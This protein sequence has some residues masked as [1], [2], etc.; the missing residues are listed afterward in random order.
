M[1]CPSPPTPR[2]VVRSTFKG[3]LKRK[4]LN[5]L[6]GSK[7][8]DVLF[9][10]GQLKKTGLFAGA[11]LGSHDPGPTS[12]G[13]SALGS[14]P[15][16]APSPHGLLPVSLLSWTLMALLVRAIPTLGLL[17]GCTSGTRP[18]TVDGHRDPPVTLPKGW[19][20][21]PSG[22]HFKM[23]QDM[24][25]LDEIKRARLMAVEA[26]GPGCLCSLNLSMIKPFFKS[27]TQANVQLAC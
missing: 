9:P 17:G 16:P 7:K 24:R 14:C 20:E 21:G 23:A 5:N 13:A 3:R 27:E 19:N 22:V 1:P 25:G 6:T 8:C 15:L 11:F 26:G 18:C 10:K 2:V 4:V 12:W